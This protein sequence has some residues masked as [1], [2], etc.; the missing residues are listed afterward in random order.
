MKEKFTVEGMTCASCQSHVEKAVRKLNGVND[1]NVNL[2][3][4]TME[5]DIDDESLK[6]K[7]CIA[8]K[9]AG[10]KAFQ[11]KEEKNEKDLSFIKL[12]ISFI[13]LILLMYVSMSHMFNLPLPNFLSGLN[14][15]LVFAITQ[16]VLTIP[17]IIIYRN[18]F[19]SGFK[20]LVKLSPNMD[21]LICIGAV[22]S[23][24]YG[25]I[26]IFMIN[27]GLN[28]NNYDLVSNYYHNLYFESCSMILTLV[29]LGKYFEERSKR[30]TTKALNKLM[31]LAPKKAIIE[32]DNSEKEI[33]VSDVKIDDV[34]V[35][36][37]GESIPVDGKIIYGSASLNQS[38]I[39]G[40]SIPVRKTIND[41][42]YASTIVTS[43]FIKVKASKIS[44][45]SSINTIIKLVE[46]AS[47][48]KAPIS[49]LVDRV[50]GI[51][52]PIVMLISIITFIISMISNN[53]FELSFNFACSVLV[54]A[55]PCALGLATPVS[56]MVGTGKG[57]E[58]GLLIKN[59]EILEKAQYIKTIVLDKT[60]TITE[61]KPT[62]CDKIS[63]DEKFDKIAYSLELYSEHPLADAI[64]N[65]YKNQNIQSVDVNDFVSLD[66]RGLKGTINGETYYAGNLLLINE[67]SLKTKELE[68]LC[69]SLSLNNKTPIVFAA[70]DKVLG[71]LGITDEIK[72]TSIYSI[73]EL[74]KL[75]IKV[76]ML[77][78]DNNKIASSIAKKVGIDEVY[79]EVLPQDKQRVINSLK[80]DDHHLVAMIG[81]GVNDALALTSSDLG[82]SVG[83]GSDIAKESSD[84][85]LL[86]NDL[87][88]V[89]NVILLSRKV[90]RTIKLN[91]FWAFF[92]N[93]IGIVLAS[94]LFYKSFNISLN[95]MIC[96]FMMSLSSVFVV[97]NALTI[98]FFKIERSEIKMKEI[99]LSIEGMMCKHC[100]KHI[101]DALSAVEG[102]SKVEVSLENKNAKVTCL[103]SLDSSKLIEAVEKEG[104]SC[105][106]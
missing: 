77:T 25:I 22:A 28:T 57:A 101:E 72:S 76:I 59:A 98:N 88:D 62:V 87:L 92:Y 73:K 31:D 17:P 60:G 38:N 32:I 4:K 29:S 12:I 41:E 1:V 20:N 100:Q 83:G 105:N 75:G 69:D 54:V 23:L 71:V 84:I 6:E 85:V 40:E 53:G 86:R 82:I 58:C 63:Y 10:Y 18:Y 15:A 7:I 42:V 68:E 80:K 50:S 104:Y 74:Q 94:G 102:V 24:I 14:N 21:S 89:K 34:I 37:K 106:I 44:S 93:S 47:S 61:G 43:G 33:D 2:L 9:N 45:D 70:K 48:S 26:A 5:V 36:R 27:Y 39:T 90:F 79:A 13:F 3:T 52:V 95:P 96:S 97:L 49:K 30:K 16:L 65:Y 66:G 64:T 55:C 81:D 51:F 67:L 8:V 46:E 11:T 78:G 103:E 35:I 99:I 91:L 19:I 56:I